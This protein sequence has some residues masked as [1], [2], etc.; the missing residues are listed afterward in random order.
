MNLYHSYTVSEQN[1]G[2]TVETY[3]KQILQYSG[4]KIQKLT[5]L[6]GIL[7]NGRTV[8]LQKKIK[9][10][11]VLK[12]RILEDESYGVLPEPGE[13]EVL[14]EDANI[15]I[16]NKPANLLVHPTGQTSRGT[17]ANYLAYYYQMHRVLCT[18]R[19]LHRL[20]RETSGCVLFAKD[21]RTQVALEKNLLD[22]TLKRSY[23]AIV[24][25]VVK[26]PSGTIN[27]PIGQ[28]STFPN[29]RIIHEKGEQAITHYR[30]IKNFFDASLLELTLETGKTHQIRLHMKYIGYPILGDRMYGIRSAW[31]NRQALHAAVLQFIHPF[32]K[33]QI[34]VL[35]PIPSDFQQL[36]KIC[37]SKLK[38]D[39]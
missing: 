21:S 13:I 2:L 22:R 35:A 33:R 27:A 10:G 32:E 16:L 34:T 9:A 18:I 19:P 23:F 1:N 11:D 3:L 14:Y 28:H 5:R 26:P 6:K 4:R 8:F 36:I 37:E 24:K 15:I 31:I 30:T 17:L 38:E 25:G 39:I 7:M 29:R 12:I 20:D